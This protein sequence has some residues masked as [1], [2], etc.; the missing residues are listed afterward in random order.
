[1]IEKLKNEEVEEVI[2]TELFCTNGYGEKE[3]YH[4]S[5]DHTG[6]RV[7]KS[8]TLED[9]INKVNEIIEKLNAEVEK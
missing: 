6:E 3:V 5:V 7:I 2:I 8:P 1:M 9:V 4:R